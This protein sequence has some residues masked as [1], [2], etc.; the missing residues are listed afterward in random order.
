MVKRSSKVTSIDADMPTSMEPMLCTL[1]D[2][3][4]GSPDYLSEYK[5]DGYRVIAYVAHGEIK[6]LSRRGKDYTS[7]YPPV[8]ASLKELN[9]VAVIDGEIGVFDEQGN[10]DFHAVQ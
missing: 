6:L 10:A 1:T 9:V 8:A 7:K 4:V 2:S 5:W 3:P